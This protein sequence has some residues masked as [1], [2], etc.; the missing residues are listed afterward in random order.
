M[1]QTTLAPETIP[2]A[3]DALQHHQLPEQPVI[4]R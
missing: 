1:I 3:S 2:A 4:A